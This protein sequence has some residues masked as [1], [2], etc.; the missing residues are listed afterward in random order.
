MMSL[1]PIIEKDMKTKMRGWRMPILL[2]LYLLFLGLVLFLFFAGNDQMFYSYGYSDFNPRTAVNAY[3]LI[4][5]F[6][7]ALLMFIV[8]ALTATSVSG[9]RERQT[10]D[11]ML[12]S[13]ISTWSIIAGKLAVSLAHVM[14][15]VIASLPILGMVLLFGGVT[16]GEMLLLL[17]FY[18]ITAVMAASL[19]IFFSTVFRKSVVS[20]IATYISLGI[21]GIGPVI[22]LVLIAVFNLG[23]RAVEPT[24]GLLALVLSPSPAFGITSFISDGQ[25]GMS[26]ID[27]FNSIQRIA[28]QDTSWLRHIAPWMLN[29]LFDL[30]LSGILVCLSA[31]KLKPVKHRRRKAGGRV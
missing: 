27:T 1:N 10:L 23:P 24:Y 14:L 8:P 11:L 20:V 2:S 22:A 3:T 31:W 28:D 6:Q 21:I 25:N 26:L 12:C 29:S 17:L 16:F 18:I 15:L 19:G 30:V 4:A 7:F 5:L 9:E 13:D